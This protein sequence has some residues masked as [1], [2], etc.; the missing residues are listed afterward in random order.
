MSVRGPELDLN[1]SAGFI[2]PQATYHSYESWLWSTRAGDAAWARWKLRAPSMFLGIEE[3]DGIGRVE[4]NLEVSSC[5]EPT[6]DFVPDPFRRYLTPLEW[7]LTP[8]D[9]GPDGVLCTDDDI[10]GTRIAVSMERMDVQDIN[11]TDVKFSLPGRVVDWARSTDTLTIAM[12]ASIVDVPHVP[13]VA[14]SVKRS[15]PIASFGL[16]SVSLHALNSRE[17]VASDVAWQTAFLNS[18]TEAAGRSSFINILPFVG[19][20][21]GTRLAAPLSDVRVVLQEDAVGVVRVFATGAAPASISAD[22][23]HPD[24]QPG[25]AISWCAYDLDTQ[26]APCVAGEVTAL[27]FEMDRL[28]VGFFRQ[29]RVTASTAGSVDGDVLFNNLGIGELVGWAT[30]ML[31]T[32]DRRTELYFAEP[33]VEPEPDPVVDPEPVVDPDPDPVVDPDPD[34]VVDPDPEP[35]VDP[36]VEPDPAP[37]VDPQPE[38]TVDSDAENT[39]PLSPEIP[40]APQPATPSAPLVPVGG[41]QVLRALPIAPAQPSPSV[42]AQPAVAHQPATPQTPVTRA[43]LATTGAPGDLLLAAL[44]LIAAGL[45]AA[46]I[47]RNRRRVG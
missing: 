47:G 29:V 17:L 30:P 23:T 14:A 2:R 20:G 38:P 3:G 11:F 5:F 16:Q 33:T 18:T 34:P 9:P 40:A 32:V 7:R 42:P 15:I 27:R 22:L 43:L 46:T 31:R 41:E 45:V 4:W 44:G 13:D 8:A 36:V 35:V 10:S 12:S 37:V 28:P 24:N 6:G 25:G 1:G 39:R 21:R 19:D 26:S